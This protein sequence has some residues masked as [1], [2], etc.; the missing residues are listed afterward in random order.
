MKSRY[1]FFLKNINLYNP[2]QNLIVFHA[3]SSKSKTDKYKA[4]IVPA[5]GTRSF[6]LKYGVH[7]HYTRM[8]IFDTSKMN[9]TM[10]FRS[11]IKFSPPALEFTLMKKTPK[12]HS[13]VVI[14][15]Q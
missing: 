4:S 1:K 11:G 9:W 12:F 2:T 5:V 7:R 13:R 14:L 15:S 10:P 8:Y 6:T 3:L